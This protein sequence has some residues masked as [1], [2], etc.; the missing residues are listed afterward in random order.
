LI[1]N[2]KPSKKQRKAPYAIALALIFIFAGIITSAQFA[3]AQPVPTAAYIAAEPNPVGVGQTIYVS[4]W[5]LPIPPSADDI[6]HHY[7]VQITKPDGTTQNMGP[8]DS[9]TIG[10]AFFAITPDQIG[11]WTFMFNY[12]GETIRGMEIQPA[13]A[14]VTVTVQQQQIQPYP[15]SPLPTGYWTR[16]IYGNNREWASIGGNWLQRGYNAEGRLWDSV[17]AYAPYTQAPR[18]PHIMWTKPLGMGG[19]AGGANDHTFYSG[20][21]YESL[22]TPPIIMEGKLFY[23]E[24]KSAFGL[25][26]G[27]IPVPNST[28]PPGVICVDLRTGEEIWKND[29]ATVDVGQLF[30]FESGNQ[31]GMV[32]YLW[33]IE[34]TT[35]YLYDANTGVQLCSFENAQ[36]YANFLGSSI[37]YGA[38]GTLF[39]Y[40]LDGNTGTLSLWNSTKAFVANGLIVYIGT[41]VGFLRVH[42]GT[43]DWSLGIEWTAHVT[44]HPVSF[45]QGFSTVYSLGITGI[46]DGVILAYYG[47]VGNY[48]DHLAYSAD[49]GEELWAFNRTLLGPLTLEAFSAIGEGIYAQFDVASEQWIAWDLHTGIQKWVSDPQVPPFGVYN[50]GTGAVIANGKMYSMAYDGY[51]HCFDTSNGKELWKFFSGNSGLDSPYGTYPFFYGPI[52]ANGVVF[53]GT[54]EHSP[55]QPLIRGEKLFAIDANTGQGLWNISGLLAI[56]AIADGYLVG[57]NGYD[58]QIYVF[59]KGPS[60]TT[61]SAPQIAIQQGTAITISGTVTDQSSGQPDTP[62]ISDADMGSYMQYLKEQQPLDITHVS[63]VPVQLTA[64][65]PDGSTITIADVISDYFGNFFSSWTPPSNGL[66][67]IIATF[68]GSDSY[69]TSSAETAITVSSVS[70]AP[71]ASPTA[72]ISP[73]PAPSTITSTETYIIITAI[74]IIVVVAITATILRRRRSK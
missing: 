62:A 29:N 6:Y 5:V 41:P 47:S 64:H 49:T 44:P 37:T 25:T 73:A 48:V 20:L 58:N 35:W 51:V 72:T 12:P 31:E 14:S 60:A 36:P 63:G 69:G 28:V 15:P 8:Y 38:D 30:D 33:S 46:S 9:E 68:P 39:V 53:A 34:G 59:G 54:G 24:Y 10:T 1:T 56:Q 4:F 26:G 45:P 13:Q 67:R 3:E 11:D 52:I 61:V 43:F 57:Y 40:F 22:L 65:A 23:R 71:S 70:P 74:V 32:P 2:S 55:T 27:D 17:G 19:I 50:G 16:P 18:A 7:T 42:P 21:S 66:Y